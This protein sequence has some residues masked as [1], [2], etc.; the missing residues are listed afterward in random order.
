MAK[1]MNGIEN[2]FGFHTDNAPDVVRSNQVWL[3]IYEMAVGH[4][5][6][7]YDRERQSKRGLA[8]G[9]VRHD[10]PTFKAIVADYQKS[11]QLSREL[12]TVLTMLAEDMPIGYIDSDDMMRR[13]MADARTSFEEDC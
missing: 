1:T 7:A 6:T 8:K 2:E 12:A 11:L 5:V 13:V 9:V 4:E 3:A 10:S